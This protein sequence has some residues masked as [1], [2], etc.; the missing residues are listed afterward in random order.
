MKKRIARIASGRLPVSSCPN[1]MHE[2]DGVTSIKMDE[3]FGRTGPTKRISL[4]G[5]ATI[6]CYCGAM[7]I[8]ADE[9][10]TMRM[11]TEEERAHI[12]FDPLVQRLIDDFRRTSIRPP[13]FTKKSYN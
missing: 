9:K 13:D 7:L 1:C 2:I 8:F 4:T 12:R 5:G 3:P 11:I 6:C 10:G